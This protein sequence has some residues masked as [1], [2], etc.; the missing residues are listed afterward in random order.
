VGECFAGYDI[1]LGSTVEADCCS[2]H[3]HATL[4]QSLSDST[5]DKGYFPLSPEQFSS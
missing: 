1:S 5:V 4:T 2:Q 3:G